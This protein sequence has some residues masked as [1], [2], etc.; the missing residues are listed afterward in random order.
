MLRDTHAPSAPWFVV[1]A[2]NKRHARI[3]ILRDLVRRIEHPARDP[4]I[5]KPDDGIVFPLR[6]NRLGL[7]AR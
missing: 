1:R 2:D 5:V 4:H 7:L 3:N 6:V